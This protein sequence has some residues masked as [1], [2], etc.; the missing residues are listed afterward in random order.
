MVSDCRKTCGRRR[1]ASLC[2][3]L[4]FTL[5]SAQLGFTQPSDPDVIRLR[6]GNV[7]H[8]Q[9]VGMDGSSI[10]FKTSAGTVSFSRDG[11]Q[12]ISFGVKDA[13][14]KPQPVIAKSPPAPKPQAQA[15]KSPAPKPN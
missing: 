10:R 14:P 8:G 11:V 13:Q 12:S 5:G 9:V 15:G 1:A 7:L 4:M 2:C 6:D 3:S